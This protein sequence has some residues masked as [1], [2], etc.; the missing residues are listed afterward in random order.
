MRGNAVETDD[1]RTIHPHQCVMPSAAGT[2]TQTLCTHT[3]VC[4]VWCVM[5]SAAGTITQTLYTIHHALYVI[6][7]THTPHTTHQA[8][9]ALS[10]LAPP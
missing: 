2:I 5:P 4:G 9:V 10:S 7:H 1:G 6:H 3:M 8:R